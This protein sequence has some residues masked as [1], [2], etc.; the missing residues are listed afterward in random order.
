MAARDYY[1]ILGVK[2]GASDKEIRQAYRRLA[3][4]HHPDVNPGDKAAEERFKEINAAY[5]VLSDAEKRRK[6]DLYGE[7]WQ[8]AD[9]FEQARRQAGQRWSWGGRGVPSG[10][11]EQFDL[12]DLGD[13]FGG[14]F[15]GGRTRPRRGE[16]VQYMTE[17]TLEEAYHGTTRVLQ[18]QG[19]E[20]CATCGGSG[21]L[22]GAVCHVCQGAGAIV[23]PRRLEVKIPPGVSDGSRVRVAGEGRPGRGGARGD[24]YLV[25]SVRPHRRFQR[26]GDDLHTEVEVPLL[27]AVLGGEVAVPTL[28]GKAMLKVPSPTQN[29]RVFRLAGLGMPKLGGGHGD[30]FVRVKVLLPTE[31]SPQERELFEKLRAAGAGAGRR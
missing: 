18:M 9:Q 6:Y 23:R 27:D 1:D 8:Y 14:L 19:E 29:G 20:P 25:I 2:R 31:F 3:R 30:L 12:G 7:Q 5:E 22:V 13:L 10:G 26:R 17:V 15:A 21:R 4:K 24:L 11:F 16:D 28:K